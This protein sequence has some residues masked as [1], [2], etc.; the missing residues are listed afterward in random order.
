MKAESPSFPLEDLL[1]L[2]PPLLRWFVEQIETFAPQ[3]WREPRGQFYADVCALNAHTDTPAEEHIG[4]F[5]LAQIVAARQ[6]AAPVDRKLARGRNAHETWY[7]KERRRIAK[8][9]LQIQDSPVVASLQATVRYY[10]AEE[11][12][13]PHG[14]NLKTCE[15]LYGLRFTLRVLERYAA[16]PGVKKQIERL[17]RREP[18]LPPLHE[19][20]LPQ[21]P[22]PE[23]LHEDDTIR[24][25]ASAT[26]EPHAVYLLGTVVSRLRQA[27]LSVADSCAV[28]DRILTCCFGQPDDH[29]SRPELLAEQWRRLC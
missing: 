9:L 21:G 19:L 4:L 29:G 6:L 27:G 2:H 1:T 23:N 13:C 10:P 3:A 26:A 25:S 11:V 5:I 16:Q 12:T 17:R 7:A 8:L 18:Y 20:C 24:F 22:P 28:V 15:A 14:H